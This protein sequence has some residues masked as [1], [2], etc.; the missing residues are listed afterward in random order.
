MKRIRIHKIKILL[1]LI[2]ILIF[3]LGL[4]VKGSN[5]YIDNNEESF[6]IYTVKSGDTFWTI[7][8]NYDYKNKMKF[9]NDIEKI[10]KINSESLKP[11]YKIAIPIYN[12]K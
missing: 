2:T 10:N 8:N 5:D 4:V 6:E 9:I 7:A 1:F 11:G 12:N 3:N